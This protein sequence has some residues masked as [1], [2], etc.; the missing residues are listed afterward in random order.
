MKNIFMLVCSILMVGCIASSESKQTELKCSADIEIIESEIKELFKADSVVIY[1][2]SVQEE[3]YFPELHSPV[4][5]IWNATTSVLDF[6][7]IPPEQTRFD[8]YSEIEDALK[9]EGFPIANKLIKECKMTNYNDLIIEF[10]EKYQ[11]GKFGDRF[12]CHYREL[13]K[14]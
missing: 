8:N 7:K 11:E 3:V 6:K 12:I 2:K 14:K 4:V 10:R 13:L 5:V 9:Q 1:V